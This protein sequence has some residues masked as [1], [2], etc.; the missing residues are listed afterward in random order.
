MSSW[1]AYKEIGPISNLI[2]Q[3]FKVSPEVVTKLILLA[4]N[5][6]DTLHWL[7]RF[8]NLNDI[9]QAKKFVR[10]IVSGGDASSEDEDDMHKLDRLRDSDLIV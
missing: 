10:L 7:M 1:L 4:R 2:A 8:I 6:R 5:D 3:I 9:Q